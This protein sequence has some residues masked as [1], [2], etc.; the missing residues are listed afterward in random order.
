MLY[1]ILDYTPSLISFIIRDREL[2]TTALS[3]KSHFLT[4]LVYSREKKKK[5]K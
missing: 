2:L 5:M 4:K 3:S 1:E